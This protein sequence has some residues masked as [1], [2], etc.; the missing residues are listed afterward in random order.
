MATPIG[1]VL[2]F[3]DTAT[4]KFTKGAQSGVEP[5]FGLPIFPLTADASSPLTTKGDLFGHSTVDARIPIGANGQILTADSSQA[6]GLKWASPTA[7]VVAA[8]RGSGIASAQATT[9]TI[10]FP[11][12]T[13]AGDLAILYC[14]NTGNNL[15][16]VPSGWTTVAATGGGTYVGFVASKILTSGDI[17]TG[18]VTV[19]V[20]GPIFSPASNACAQIVTF[21][22]P[23]GGV[24]EC[25][26][27][28]DTTSGGPH[29]T[30]SAVL[31]SDVGI[32][33]A[34][35]GTISGSPSLTISP[36]TSLQSVLDANAVGQLSSETMPG[37]VTTVTYT[38]GSGVGSGLTVNSFVIIEGLTSGVGTVT[39]VA[40]T[41]PSRQSVSG[42][43]VTGSGTLA[44][45]DNTQN[46]NLVF[47]GPS[48]GSAAA[49]TFRA[50]VSADVP[51]SLTNPMTAKGDI[52][53]GDTSGA[54][55]RLAAGTSGQVLQ[56][57]GSGAAPTWVTPSGGGGG[58]GFSIY[59]TMTAPLA[60]NFSFL[61][62][63]GYAVSA[64]DKTARLVIVIPGGATGVA[65]MQTASLPSAPYTIDA[66][67]LA[68]S[69]SGI[70]VASLALK[71]SSGGAIR[72]YGPRIDGGAFWYLN[73]QSWSSV[74]GPGAQNNTNSAQYFLGLM[75]FV[76]IT[77]DGT[78]RITYY[79]TNGKD[80]QLWL[81]Q[82]S[83]TG[84]SPDK[85]GL[86]FYNA[87]TPPITLSVYHWLISNS[88]LPQFAT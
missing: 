86:I 29:S 3:T 72:S 38:Y 51:G 42:S 74:T 11:T 73:D 78:N 8:I 81:S 33:F 6:L 18:S 85:T 41:V 4:V 15:S 88:V 1:E 43:P 69:T 2:D 87:A 46:A 24:R 12:G 76:R 60:A 58:G 55:A 59:P 26:V 23:T 35:G 22:G 84:L 7:L 17:S 14:A 63:S 31:S 67:F 25:T 16:G 10:S 70:L 30:S 66:G 53:Y 49:P 83:G 79:S 48:S 62:P 56:T 36:G 57:N 80:Y 77:D 75:F 50:L 40:L 20:S 54:P 27:A 39:S 5:E 82:A 45:S 65:L 44:I 68:A 21:V 19:D 34:S 52:I 37:G 32:F 64:T 61:N 71:N 47:A 28:V 13:L 9:I